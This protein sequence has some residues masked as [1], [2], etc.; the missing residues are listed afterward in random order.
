MS[1]QPIS[2]S[3]D[4]SRLVAEGFDIDIAGPH[5]IV[6]QVPY[7]AGDGSLRH[8][9]LVSKLALAGDVTIR[10][11]DHVMY[12]AGSY[13]HLSKGVPI[14]A[15]RH[16]S[17]T[18]VMGG[19]EVHHSFSSKPKTGFYPDYW[20]KVTT[21]AAILCGPTTKVDPAATP[22]V[23]PV[24]VPEA[25][26]LEE[27][28]LYL[29]TATGRAGLE[30]AASRLEGHRL[31]IVGLGG[32]GAYILDLVA[33]TPVAEIHL[34]DGDR[35]LQHN[36]FRAPGAAS[37]E[38]LAAQMA[39]VDYLAEVYSKMRRGV[40]P[41]AVFLDGDNVSLLEDLSFVFIALDDNE[42]RATVGTYLAER[43][44]PFVDV[45][46]GV[47]LDDENRLAGVIRVTTVTPARG[48]HL[49]ARL[50]TRSVGR[51]GEYDTNIQ[52]A[53]LNAL[54]AA[55]AVVRWKKHVGFYR[56]LEGEHH[57]TYT[58]DGNALTNEELADED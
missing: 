54:N 25:E 45:G 35:M 31:G 51:D 2:R 3:P 24:R 42:A 47:E 46:M 38:E 32:T 56:D 50:P 40:L 16:Q 29:D 37:R 52:I 39:K 17:K 14:E 13:P 1:R 20:H 22:A 53:E 7:L 41:H 4:L 26:D 21:Y 30:A 10:P 12:F 27:P 23:W 36:A 9:T 28:F 33:K 57:T 49:G 5:L 18:Q 15:I 11:D 8:G 55:L 43:G 48:G 6:R 44:V 19:I 58:L 34:F